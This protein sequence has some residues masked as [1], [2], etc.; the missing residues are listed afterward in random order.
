MNSISCQFLCLANS[1]ISNHLLPAP[2]L[3]I[4]LFLPLISSEMR[5][6]IEKSLQQRSRLLFIQIL[7]KLALSVLCIFKYSLHPLKSRRK[8]DALPPSDIRN[9]CISIRLCFFLMLVISETFFTFVFESKLKRV[10][11]K[12]KFTR[13]KNMRSYKGDTFMPFSPKLAASDLGSYFSKRI[14]DCGEHGS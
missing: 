13:I 4:P 2:F 5:G 6:S 11:N 7:Y 12:W 14:K 3:H 9:V 10:P 1:L 8:C